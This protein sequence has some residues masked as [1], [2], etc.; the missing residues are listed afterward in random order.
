M[1]A[2]F[3]ASLNSIRF[4]HLSFVLLSIVLR[5]RLAVSEQPAHQTTQPVTMVDVIGMRRL[6]DAESGGSI[7][8]FSPNG[9][10][11]VIVTRRGV[12]ERNVN[13]YSLLLWKT[14][15]ILSAKPPQELAKLSSSSNRPA[16]QQVSWIDDD[17]L[18]F[19]GE[20][21]NELQQ[22]YELNLTTRRLIRITNHRSNL[23]S[24]SV[25][26]GGRSIAFLAEEPPESIFDHNSRQEG[27]IVGAQWLPQLL[28]GIKGPFD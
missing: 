20:H 1:K 17:T 27:L 25:S 24:Y 15:Q 14:D 5:D 8:H 3:R 18:A 23:I 11:C 28:H 2:S 13:E 4:A 7:A 21:E 12:L 26:S 10:N 16:I 19:L 22:L 6:P 9:K